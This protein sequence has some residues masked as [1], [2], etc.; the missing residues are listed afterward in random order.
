MRNFLLILFTCC[1]SFLQA[2][3]YEGKIGKYPIFLELEKRNNDDYIRAFYFYKNQLDNIPLDGTCNG[4]EITLFQEYSK[5]EAEKELFSL[6][7]NGNT[8]NGTWQNG[9]KKLQVELFQTTENLETFKR[10]NLSFVRDS[11]V[12]YNQKELVWFTEK[13]SK[14]QLFRLGNGFTK[15]E[16]EFMN[17]ILDSIHLEY[18]MIGLDCSWADMYISVELVSDKYISFS[19]Q[20][21]IYCGGAQPSHNKVGYN[22]DLKNSIQLKRLTDYK[23]QLD[24]YQLLKNKYEAD[25]GLQEECEYFGGDE[26]MW[27]Y[28]SWFL[29]DKGVIITPFFPHALTPCKEGFFLTYEELEEE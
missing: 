5:E 19:E 17:P 22:F 10:K 7:L 24:Y 16:R 2:Q 23:P 21:S 20:S 15:A 27:K 14:K 28:C 13:Y 3:T 29:T 11:V 8:L 18:A 9:D 4:S 25:T 26:F 12:A 1:F 6:I